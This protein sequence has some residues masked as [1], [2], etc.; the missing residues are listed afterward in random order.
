M[1]SLF[2]DVIT[3]L[4]ESLSETAQ[5]KLKEVFDCKNLRLDRVLRSLHPLE[6][7]KENDKLLDPL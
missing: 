3:K 5:K 6:E 2:N 7:N 1:G 4:I